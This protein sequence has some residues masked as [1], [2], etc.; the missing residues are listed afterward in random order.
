M[1]TRPYSSVRAALVEHPEQH[2]EDLGGGLLDLV[3][4]DDGERLRADL[5]DQFARLP[6]GLDDQAP[7]R[8]GAAELA[9]VQPHEA[10]RRLAAAEQ[11][12][13]QRLRQGG[14]AHAGRAAEEHHARAAAADRSAPP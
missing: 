4:Q 5:A 8:P 3:E 6:V 9:H 1:A 2:V 11:V 7:G 12:V 13:G 14:L 10:R